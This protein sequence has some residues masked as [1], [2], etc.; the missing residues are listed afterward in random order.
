MCRKDR[1]FSGVQLFPKH[2]HK[3]MSILS[4]FSGSSYDKEIAQVTSTENNIN[5]SVNFAAFLDVADCLKS[6]KW[7]SKTFCQSLVKRLSEKD[8]G[9]ILLNTLALC[10]VCVKNAGSSF[11]LSFSTR[12]ITDQLAALSRDAV[13]RIQPTCRM[14][15]CGKRQENA[16]K[17][18]LC[19]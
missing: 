8:N 9:N 12:E 1:F 14:P 15:K 19:S 16:F 10:D 11:L 17:L 18:G 4:L 7:N 2:K 13:G 5:G 3:I 6:G